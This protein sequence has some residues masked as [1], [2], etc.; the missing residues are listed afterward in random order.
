[1]NRL[2]RSVLLAFLLILLN[3]LIWLLFGLAVAAGA[4]P[5]I[6]AAGGMRWIMAAL[7]LGSAAFLVGI[8]FF[9]RRHSRL[10]YYLALGLLAVISVLA[11]TDQIG[12]LDLAALLISLVPLVLLLKDRAWYLGPRNGEHP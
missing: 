3:A 2:P 1:M 8:V 6:P 7:A 9:L 4:I 12:L 10:A 5:S 11:L